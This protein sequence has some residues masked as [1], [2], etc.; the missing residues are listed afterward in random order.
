MKVLGAPAK[1]AAKPLMDAL[2]PEWPRAVFAP[3]LAHFVTLR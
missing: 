3:E 2:S 1:A